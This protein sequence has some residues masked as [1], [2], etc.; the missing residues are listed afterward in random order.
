MIEIQFLKFMPEITNK[1]PKHLGKLK[2]K[3][4]IAFTLV[5]ILFLVVPNKLVSESFCFTGFIY[6]D[7]Q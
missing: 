5:I 4:I 6:N 2:I 1:C 7:W 3:V